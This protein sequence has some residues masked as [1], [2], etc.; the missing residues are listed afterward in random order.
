MERYTTLVPAFIIKIRVVF[1]G[2]HMV[3]STAIMI[4]MHVTKPLCNMRFKKSVKNDYSTNL[5]NIHQT[6]GNQFVNRKIMM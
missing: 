4:T 3:Q 2:S 6:I 5:R 1:L